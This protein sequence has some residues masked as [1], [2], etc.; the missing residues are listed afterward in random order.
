MVKTMRYLT[1]SKSTWS[2][3]FPADYSTVKMAS[4]SHSIAWLC[5]SYK[6]KSLKSWMRILKCVSG[7]KVGTNI[8]EVILKNTCTYKSCFSLIIP[9]LACKICNL[10]SKIVLFSE[11]LRNYSLA[12]RFAFI[13]NYPRNHC[14]TSSKS[15]WS[16]SG[17][18]TKKRSNQAYLKS[19]TTLESPALSTK[20]SAT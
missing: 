15:I 16:Q 2:S 1:N 17:S 6:W 5:L 12:Q 19:L 9:T 18:T 4:L 7:A 20:E 11:R 8:A 14:I 13:R 10:P 3:S